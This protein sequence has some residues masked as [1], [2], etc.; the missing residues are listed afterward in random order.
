MSLL[1]MTTTSRLVDEGRR[2]ELLK[3]RT[4]SQNAGHSKFPWDSG[5]RRFVAVDKEGSETGVAENVN[6]HNVTHVEPAPDGP[7]QPHSPLTKLDRY[8]LK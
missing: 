8:S 5:R 3:S 2:F 4:I 1:R 7:S 6:C